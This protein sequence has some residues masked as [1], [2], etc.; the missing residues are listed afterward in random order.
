MNITYS[1]QFIKSFEF[2][3]KNLQKRIRTGL[4][5]L[6]DGNIKKLK[7]NYTPP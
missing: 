1:K 6:P 3:D 2:L 5:K 7:G 4:L